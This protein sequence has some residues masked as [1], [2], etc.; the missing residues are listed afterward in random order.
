[1]KTINVSF[2][3]DDFKEV[4]ESKRKDTWVKFIIDLVRFKKVGDKQ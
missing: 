3:D 1:M 2:E 4:K